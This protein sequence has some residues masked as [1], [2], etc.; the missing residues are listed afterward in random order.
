MYKMA[1]VQDLSDCDMANH[2][3]IA[4]RLIGIFPDDADMSL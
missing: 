3:K 2:S 4:E 1:V